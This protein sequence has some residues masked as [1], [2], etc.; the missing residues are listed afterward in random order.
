MFKKRL[1]I[2]LCAA[3]FAVF[4]QETPV[5]GTSASLTDAARK[6]VVE[7]PEVLA[8]WHEYEAA[9]EQT[10]VAQ[11]G[12]LPRVDLE[13]GVGEERIDDPRYAE[14]TFG[15]DRVSVSLS[16]MLFD[17]F[18]TRNEVRRLNH[19]A[20]TRYYEVLEASEQATAE[21]ARA[22]L[23]VLRHR[24]LVE[25]SEEN[26]ATHRMIYDQIERRVRAGVSRR[27][28]LE[29]V[30]G[31][32]ALSESNLLTDITNL[33]DV[34]MRYQRIVGEIPAEKLA[35]PEI[36]EGL[37]PATIKETLQAA[38]QNSPLMNAAIANM[39]SAE[40]ATDVAKAAYLPR[41]DL[42]ARQDVWHDKDDINGRY[43]Q[44]IVE[45]V[46]RYNLFNGG[47][48]SA[49]KRRLIEK[50]YQAVDIRNKTCRDIRQDVSIAWNNT[51][52][53]EEQMGYLDRHQ[54]AIE[55]A[56]EAY[57]RQF[58]IGQRTL[59][60]ILDTENEYYEARRAYLNAERDH[61]IA[62]ARTLA[63]SGKLVAALGLGSDIHEMELPPGYDAAN[64]DMYAVCPQETD[65]AMSIDKDKVF[66]DAMQKRGY[67]QPPA[68][69]PAS[70]EPLP[71]M[72]GGPAPDA[73]GT[74][75][76]PAATPEEPPVPSKW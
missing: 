37:L 25:L 51:R 28:D 75:D 8:A 56:R 5:P 69:A 2:A 59:L 22:Y 33:H 70:G 55:K 9:T 34:S 44:G 43:E 17:G 12:Y 1:S 20:R 26:Y 71:Y 27:V 73:T 42:Q 3:S 14:N 19:A 30:S 76:A 45:L 24:G 41:F 63:G 67:M 40:A 6:S 53:L 46:M 18:R 29:Q 72:K 39:W 31:R 4:A 49:E 54:L 74:P 32:L 10:R 16:Q 50:T 36:P 13:A 47:S 62:Y 60:D 58:D 68:S 48:D 61:A 35:E 7:N 38:Y 57:K 66:R 23:D 52:R 15:R 64:P 65:A 21:T 11:G